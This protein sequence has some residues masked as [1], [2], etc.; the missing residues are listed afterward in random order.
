M[1]TRKTLSPSKNAGEHRTIFREKPSISQSERRAKCTQDTWPKPA[2]GKNN[3]PFP[4]KVFIRVDEP[5]SHR[6]ASTATY[7][8]PKDNLFG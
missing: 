7:I 4:Y 6:E 8:I 1:V 3:V 2:S 5:G